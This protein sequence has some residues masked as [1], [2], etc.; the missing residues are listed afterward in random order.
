MAFKRQ[1]AQEWQKKIDKW[2]GIDTAKG[3]LTQKTND[4]N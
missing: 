2:G 3:I 4:F 1:E